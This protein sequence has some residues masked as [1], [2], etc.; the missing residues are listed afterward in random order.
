MDKGKPYMPIFSVLDSLG[1]RYWEKRY[2]KKS[3]P[4]F[5]DKGL[6]GSKDKGD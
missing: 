3:V 1:T 5:G 6:R 2:V 4:S